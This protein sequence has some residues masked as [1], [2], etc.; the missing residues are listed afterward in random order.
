MS[1]AVLFYGMTKR[2]VRTLVRYGFDS[3]TQ[4]VSLLLLFALLF[5]GAKAVI[6]PSG[7]HSQTLPSIVSGYFVWM[8]AVFGYGSAAGQL[9]E[10]ATT[11]TLEQLAMSPLGLRTVV[12]TAFAASWLAQLVL[13]VGCFVLMMLISGTWL[14]ID[15]VSLVPLIFLTSV[16]IFGVGLLTGGLAL[17][18][19]RTQ[20]LL[21]LLQFGFV[22]LVAAPLDRL[23]WFKYLPLAWGNVLIRR[24][25][26]Q[27]QSIFSMRAGDVLF[28]VVHA[29]AWL[30][31]GLFAFARLERIA[32][33]RALLGHY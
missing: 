20:A 19:K 23:P 15:V 13:L 6:G 22:G 27:G 3:V 7:L 31:F 26:V 1:T 16:G 5:Y 12:V 9:L 24:V 28:L 4:I 8:L 30:A 32:R 10:E 18:F 11:G 14:H 21:Q 25:M 2:G 33:D 29:A 17:I